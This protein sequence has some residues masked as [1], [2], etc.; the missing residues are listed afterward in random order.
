MPIYNSDIRSRD[1]EGVTVELKSRSLQTLTHVAVHN[2]CMILRPAARTRL[3]FPHRDL[4]STV[5]TRFNS[6]NQSGSAK[7]F[8]DAEREESEA[9]AAPQSQRG[10]SRIPFLEQ[11]HENWTGEESMQDAVL[12]MLVDKYK[13]LRSGTIQTAEQKIKQAPPKV[14][15]ALDIRMDAASSPPPAAT[16]MQPSSGSWATETLIPS[17]AGHRP[18]HTEFKVPTHSTSSIKLGIPPL[19]SSRPQKPV[20]VDERLRR[21]E[22]EQ[23]KRT[24]QVGRLSRAKESMLDY[25]LGIKKASKVGHINPISIKGWAGLVEDKIEVCS[26]SLLHKFDANFESRKLVRLAYSTL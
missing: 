16:F 14:S 5:Y 25:R 3:S 4:L 8:A 7:L 20:A 17:T 26:Q 13:P 1:V 21:K 2:P 22:R 15:T 18:W 19:S 23:Q 24:E 6:S 9:A 11:Q 10:A 12:R